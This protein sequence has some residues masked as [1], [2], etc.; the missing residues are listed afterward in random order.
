MKIL[1]LLDLQNDFLRQEGRLPVQFLYSKKIID[2]LNNRVKSSDFDEVIS[3][4]N[5]FSKYD[6]VGNFFRKCSAIKGSSGQQFD[7]RLKIQPDRTFY[8]SLPNALSN[9]ELKQHL[10]DM[11]PDSIYVAGVFTHQCV[12]STI[13]GLLKITKDITLISEACGA[14]TEQNHHKG[15]E[16]IKQLGIKIIGNIEN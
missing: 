3:V 12:L 11:C 8:K 5:N 7:D 4:E 15:I 14:N 9:K 1:L 2:Y 10:R 16:K 6:I 13:K